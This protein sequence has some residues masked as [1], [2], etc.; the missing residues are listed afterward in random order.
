METEPPAASQPQYRDGPASKRDR[1]G[2]RSGQW[3]WG[4]GEK[5][6][7]GLMKRSEGG[8]WREIM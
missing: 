1:W 6:G 3:G 2:E 7:W 5:G 4:G 8:K